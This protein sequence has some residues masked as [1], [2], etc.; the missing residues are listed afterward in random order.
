MPDIYTRIV[1]SLDKGNF[2]CSVFLDFKAI[3]KVD[4]ETLISKLKTYVTAMGLEPTTT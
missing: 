1:N 4:H 3:D 2:A